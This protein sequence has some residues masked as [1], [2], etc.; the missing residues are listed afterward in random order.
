MHNEDESLFTRTM[1]GVMKDIA[2]FCKHD[3]VL[4]PKSVSKTVIR[5]GGLGTLERS[6]ADRPHVNLHSHTCRIRPI[7]GSNRTGGHL[8]HADGHPLPY[9][10]L[11]LSGPRHGRHGHRAPVFAQ[12]ARVWDVHLGHLRYV[13]AGLGL[14]P[15]LGSFSARFESTGNTSIMSASEI[16]AAAMSRRNL[17]VDVLVRPFAL[18][19]YVGLIFTLLYVWSESFL[20]VFLGIYHWREQLFGPSFLGLFVGAFIVKLPFFAYLYYVQDPKYNDKGE[21]KPDERIPVAIVGAFLVPTC[22]FWFGCTPRSSVHRIVP[23][24]RLKHVQRRRARLLSR[25]T[26]FNHIEVCS[27]PQNVVLNYLAGAYPTYAASVL[28]G[29]NVI[30]SM[31]GAIFPLFAGASYRNLGVGWVTTLLALRRV[32]A[33]S[34]LAVQVRQTDPDG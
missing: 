8:R 32:R 17:A 5:S 20:F 28:A 1:Q 25:L 11:W 16:V 30:C 21:L 19:V 13:G 14:G 18:N 31:L 10:I 24:H 29:N 9:G 22:L 15:L 33:H 23:D 27:N 34:D 4:L 7:A 12:E 3:S 6:P 26:L 2:Y